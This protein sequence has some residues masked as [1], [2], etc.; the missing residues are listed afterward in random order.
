MHEL[1]LVREMM[2]NMEKEAQSAG[3]KRIT[4]VWLKLN[5]LSGFDAEDVQFSFELVKGERSF[6]AGASLIL[7]TLPPVAICLDCGKDWEVD[8]LPGVCPS[9]GSVSLTPREKAG[10]I[11][12]RYEFET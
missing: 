4:T 1:T 5:P 3:A 8:E 12:E 2:E 7:S 6:F 11:V 10:L 9:C